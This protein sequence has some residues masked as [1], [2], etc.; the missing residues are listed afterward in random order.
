[1]V[2][3]ARTQSRG[4]GL[5]AAATYINA[6]TPAGA[7]VLVLWG[8]PELNLL[9]NRPAG[10]RF[11]FLPPYRP[12]GFLQQQTQDILARRPA[13]VLV[14]PDV[15]P[16]DTQARQ[17]WLA[18]FPGRTLDADMQAAL[19]ELTGG[20]QAQATVGADQWHIYAPRDAPSN[21]R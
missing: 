12:P 6:N 8:S 15:P 7:S 4:D 20:Y 9:T 3:E 2:R 14:P 18:R 16:I 10:S 5:R 21:S 11:L 19:D 13:F 1:L 17:A